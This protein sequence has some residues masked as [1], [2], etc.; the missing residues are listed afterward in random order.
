MDPVRFGLIGSGFM[1]RT[2]AEALRNHVPSA[3]LVAV[4]MGSRAA[5]LAADYDVPL[6]ASVGSLLG[7]DDVEAVV[8]ATPHSTHLPLTRQAAAAGRHVYIEKPMALNVAECDGMIAACREA[9]V[10]LTVNKV[11]RYRE[12]PLTAKRL[13]DEGRIGELRMVRVTSSVVGYLPNDH[14]WAKDPGE[15]GAWLDMGVHLF[16]ALRWFS[17]SD[18][19]VVFAHVADFGGAGLRRSGMAE[20]VMRNGVMAQVWISF[21][22]P[23][24]GIGSQSQWL[25]VGSTGIVESDSYG[26]VRLGTG[27]GWQEVFEMPPF[28][29]NSD[30]VSP[31]RLKAFATQVEDFARAVRE[32]REPDTPAEE[33][34]KA[35]ELVEATLRSSETKTAVR[36]PLAPA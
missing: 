32:V 33:G 8:I 23:P 34:R 1:A 4:A 16:D 17:G 22:M 9:G 13:I 36:L 35:V 10:R 28:G 11:T 2:Y 21:E 7:R 18:A 25:F 6:E 26:K 3:K 27:D 24:P 5:A 12:S 29:L 31:I 15:G 14:G 19:D 30:T 20:L